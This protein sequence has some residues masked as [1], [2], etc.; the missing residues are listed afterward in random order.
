LPCAGA[1]L[2]LSTSQFMRLPIE[3]RLCGG[4]IRRFRVCSGSSTAK[5]RVEKIEAGVSS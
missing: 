1:Q 5:I 2:L 3:W 4:Q